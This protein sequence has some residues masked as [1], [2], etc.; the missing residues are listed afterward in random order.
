M[1]LKR[2]RH[3]NLGSPNLT[4]LFKFTI[5]FQILS[6]N[7]LDLSSQT[8]D[9][10][11]VPPQG[12]PNTQLWWWVHSQLHKIT[13]WVNWIIGMW[14][15]WFILIFYILNGDCGS[16]FCIISKVLKAGHHQF[17]LVRHGNSFR[18]IAG[19]LWSQFHLFLHPI[20]HYLSLS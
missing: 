12:R 10:G 5:W 6:L 15:R 7:L 1:L 4:D 20:A 9:R 2:C 11:G 16:L 18:Y 14:R 3:V 19:E 17:Q 13:F 8:L